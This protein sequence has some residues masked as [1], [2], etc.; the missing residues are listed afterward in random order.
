MALPRIPIENVGS[1]HVRKVGH[2][3]EGNS[4]ESAQPLS[5]IIGLNEA[6]AK[7]VPY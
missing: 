2:K 4:F 1:T 5:C 3:T 7:E 6:Q